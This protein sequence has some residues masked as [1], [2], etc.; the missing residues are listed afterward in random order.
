VGF[1]GN[2]MSYLV[3]RGRWYDDI[4]LLN[5]HAPTDDKSDD[6]KDSF[7]EALNQMFDRFPNYHMNIYR[8]IILPA[9]FL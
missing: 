7:Y 8:A 1:V 5:A 6:S 3:L 9:V 4:F 2:G